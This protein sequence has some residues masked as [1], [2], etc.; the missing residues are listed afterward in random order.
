MRFSVK[1]AEPGRVWMGPLL[2][3]FWAALFSLT[4]VFVRIG[5]LT[6]INELE[7]NLYD[8]RF[9]LRSPRLSSDLVQVIG[10]TDKDLRDLG[11]WPWPR[12]NQ[13]A[14]VEV[15][16]QYGPEM[17]VFDIMFLQ[18]QDNYQNGLGY[19]ESLGEEDLAQYSEEDVQTLKD[20]WKIARQSDE[21]FAQTIRSS[22][23]VYLACFFSESED[24]FG[25][26]T[27]QEQESKLFFI[28]RF[29][30]DLPQELLTAF[31][32]G[33]RA[34]LPY[35][36]LV[37]KAAGVGFINVHKDS[38]GTIRRTPLLMEH[39]GR[40][41]P[42]LDLLVLS[43][44][45][46][47]DVE[48]YSFD[49]SHGLCLHYKH[50]AERQLVIPTD[51]HGRQQ[52]NFLSR[53]AFI[54]DAWAFQDVLRSHLRIQQAE[55]PVVPLEN[56]QGKI[57]LV[58]MFVTG[59]PDIN[60]V[61]L[62][63]N[64]PLVCVHATLMDNVIQKQYVRDL[65][66]EHNIILLFGLGLV[67]GW[68]TASLGTLLA[69]LLT[70]GFLV[71]Y[72]VLSFFLFSMT[73]PFVLQI[74]RPSLCV[75]GTFGTTQ[76]YNL[77]VARK[78]RE[79]VKQI[80]EGYVSQKVAD[81]VL[82]DSSKL[83]LGGIRRKVTILYADIRDFTG[84]AEASRPEMVVGLLNTFFGEMVQAIFDEQGTVDKFIGDCVMGL[85]GAPTRQDDQVLRAVRTA[86]KMQE[87]M[88]KLQAQF[89]QAGF[90][91]VGIGVGINTGDVIVGHI[92]TE[93]KREYTVI[94][95]AVNVAFRLQGIAEPG[96]ILIS[97]TSHREVAAYAKAEPRDPVLLKGK[98]VPIRIYC[99][100]GLHED[101]ATI[102]QHRGRI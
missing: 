27:D 16:N 46:D 54:R 22:G 2:G 69:S 34:Q 57:V 30:L 100:T 98:E 96:E 1:R 78:E 12:A 23:N 71:A 74:I 99:I 47:L 17:I 89:G 55:E 97:E 44:F 8:V 91:N 68:M 65:S 53:T 75:L 37:E 4:A 84:I 92:G 32:T 10:I 60:P 49:A 56:I 48:T 82:K 21:Q 42:S 87:R 39:G 36:P 77:L 62:H 38:D 15:L 83:A 51:G 20:F 73:N 90:S 6:I 26:F 63:E 43:H 29:S 11:P 81:E 76:I 9:R 101:E 67:V 66:L 70:V 7:Q 64:Y 79:R 50:S 85:F 24:D 45:L 13:K 28:D 41:Y 88:K 31:P 33:Y 5:P 61:P 3:L 25:L 40:V 102:I 72:L 14:L 19:L 80:L 52:V 86:L 95:D 93:T 94:G 35:G 59:F 18:D 58:G